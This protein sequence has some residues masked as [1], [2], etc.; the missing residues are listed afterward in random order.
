MAGTRAMGGLGSEHSEPR[1]PNDFY[2][3]PAATTLALL[4][5]ERFEGPIWECA[6][7]LGAISEVLKGAGYDVISTDL[8]DRGYGEGGRDFLME[9]ELLAPNILTNPPF[10]EADA[11]A[12]HALSLGAEKIALF[13][14]TAWVEGQTRHR[15][16]WSRHPPVRIWQ[17]ASRQTL[18]KGNDPN[19]KK[20]GGTISFAWF[21]WEA[22]RVDAPTF[23]WLA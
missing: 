9:K 11:F 3:T 2:A 20:T 15:R 16:L 10:G 22:G 5:K 12:I 8:I 7:G 19:A 13:M 6:A 4:S 17:F 18:Y 21:V 1:E 23:G 14:R